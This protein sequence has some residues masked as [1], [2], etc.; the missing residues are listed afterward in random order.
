MD[1]APQSGATL[2]SKGDWGQQHKSVATTSSAS[3]FFLRFGVGSSSA[4]LKVGLLSA[5]EYMN[6]E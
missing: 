4:L 3:D 6:E 2:S 1:T 5:G